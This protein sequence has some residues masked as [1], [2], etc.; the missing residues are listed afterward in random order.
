MADVVQYV[1]LDAWAYTWGNAHLNRV[2][3]FAH[4]HVS[5]QY[6]D[7]LLRHLSLLQPVPHCHWFVDATATSCQLSVY[8]KTLT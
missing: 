4:N 5:I 1:N 6:E 2:E 3:A 7:D 8:L